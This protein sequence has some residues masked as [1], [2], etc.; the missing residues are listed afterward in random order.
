MMTRSIRWP[1][2][3]QIGV[4]RSPSR[5]RRKGWRRVSRVKHNMSSS[6]KNR[7]TYVHSYHSICTYIHII[8]YV[9]TFISFYTYVHSYHSICTY[10]HI[11][12]YVRTF[13]SFYMYVHSYHSICTYI[14]IIL[15]VRTFISFYMYVHS[16]HSICT[17]IHIILYV[18]T[19]ISFYMYV[20]SYHSICTYILCMDPAVPPPTFIRTYMYVS[21]QWL[22]H[23]NPIGG[24]ECKP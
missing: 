11:I 2:T 10:I 3:W 4:P 6:P 17:Y 8:L 22:T 7:G 14:H 12:L 18:R 5:T 19:F 21:V 16:Y 9:R 1:V 15:Y 20:H 23:L 13:I 24:L